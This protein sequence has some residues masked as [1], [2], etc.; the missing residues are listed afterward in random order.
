M[1]DPDQEWCHPTDDLK[2]FQDSANDL[3][4]GSAVQGT[5]GTLYTEFDDLRTNNVTAFLD[6]TYGSGT[7]TSTNEFRGYPKTTVTAEFTEFAGGSDTP[8]SLRVECTIANKVG[9]DIRVDFQNLD[10][11]STV[12]E[13]TIVAGNRSSG[14][15]PMFT[16]GGADIIYT[17]TWYSTTSTVQ[18]TPTLTGSTT[19]T[20]VFTTPVETILR[21]FGVAAV[22]YDSDSCA[23]GTTATGYYLE[24]IWSS[25]AITIGVTGITLYQGNKN[26]N[27]G[28]TTAASKV[29]RRS[30]LSLG[31][32]KIVTDSSGVISTNVQCSP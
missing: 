17:M 14:I 9:Y 12:F 30:N 3:T 13:S 29:F 26:S 31:F 4:I 7:V 21:D 25:S 19:G 10:V 6:S 8:N 24:H 1:V 23:A 11:D 2:M 16:T 18:Y 5:S 27:G 28:N 20:L 22:F 15:S 32:D